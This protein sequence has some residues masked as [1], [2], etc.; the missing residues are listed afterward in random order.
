[1]T[2]IQTEGLNVLIAGEGYSLKYI[3]SSRF[4]RKLYT[5]SDKIIEGIV[6]IDF[7]TFKELAKKCKAFQIDLVIVE[8]KRW[9][10]EGISDVLRSNFVNCIAP[11]AKWTELG[12]PTF[13]T[14]NILKKYGINLPEITLLPA[15]FPLVVKG[16]GV[17]RK[18]N[19]VQEVI[20]IREEV[21]K[22]SSVIARDLYLEKYL[23]G[24]KITISS[25]F[26]T[27]NLLTFPVKDIPE[28]II[29]NY[30]QYFERMLNNE[31]ASFIGFIN[32]EVILYNNKL[33]N[34]GISFEFPTLN[35]DMDILYI[36]WL[37]IYQKLDEVSFY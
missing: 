2:E 36:L 5:T 22:R 13:E 26:D 35:C 34:V 6:N 21:H 31:N 27:K 12:V 19:S 9:I 29:N 14:R 17:S 7:N 15:N 37:A 8:D 28:D 18:V 3:Q 33:Y 30:S 10:N 23:D 11:S 16:N 20:E 24:K 25:L 1:M 32:S 4:L